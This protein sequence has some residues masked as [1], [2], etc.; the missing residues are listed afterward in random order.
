MGPGARRGLQRLGM[1]ENCESMV[2]LYNLAIEEEMVEL[3]VAE[4]FPFNIEDAKEGRAI[5]GT[6]GVPFELREIEHSLCEFDKYQRAKTGVGR[7]RQNYNGRAD[8]N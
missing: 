6:Y 1:P 8:E 2:R 5:D 4:H 3:H 7:P